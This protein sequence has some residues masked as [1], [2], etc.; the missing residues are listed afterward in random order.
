LKF[1]KQNA[2]QPRITIIKWLNSQ[3]DHKPRRTSY[4]IDGEGIRLQRDN[5]KV[6]LRNSLVQ[7]FVL[8]FKIEL[9]ITNNCATALRRVP[10]SPAGGGWAPP[11]R[12]GGRC[13]CLE[14]G[15]RRLVQHGADPETCAQ[16]LVWCGRQPEAGATPRR[17]PPSPVPS[18]SRLLAVA[19]RERRPFPLLPGGPPLQANWGRHRSTSSCTCSPSPRYVEVVG[20]DQCSVC[21]QLMAYVPTGISYNQTNCLITISSSCNWSNALVVISKWSPLQF[22]LVAIC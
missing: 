10:S 18:P 11:A 5:G 16:R 7:L 4:L 19:C 1:S 13:G 20:V 22:V 2:E 17:A 8:L 9:I 14:A 3:M 15:A 6:H 12:C 21:N